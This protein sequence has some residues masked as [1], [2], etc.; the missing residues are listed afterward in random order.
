MLEE[1]CKWQVKGRGKEK[2][3]VTGSGVCALALLNEITLARSRDWK[4]LM[5]LRTRTHAR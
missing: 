5:I 3:K 1:G 4:D 2:K